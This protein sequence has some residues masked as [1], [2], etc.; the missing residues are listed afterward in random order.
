MTIQGKLSTFSTR[1]G[2]TR[3]MMVGNCD[4][5]QQTMRR[6]GYRKEVLGFAAKSSKRFD[7]EVKWRLPSHPGPQAPVTTTPT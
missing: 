3:G 7:L 5:V 4:T 6:V 1:H 2:V